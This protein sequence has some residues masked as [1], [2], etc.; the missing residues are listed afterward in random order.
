MAVVEIQLMWLWQIIVDTGHS[1]IQGDESVKACLSFISFLFH[2]GCS[3]ISIMKSTHSCIFCPF[4]ILLPQSLHNRNSELVKVAGSCS[5]SIACFFW[6]CLS[7]KR[8][9]S[10]SPSTWKLIHS[11]S[12]PGV[13]FFFASHFLVSCYAENISEII[14]EEESLHL[15][16]AL[17]ILA[18]SGAKSE[19]FG[20]SLRYFFFLSHLSFPTSSRHWL[21]W[22][23]F[24]SLT[25]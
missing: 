15:E 18:A 3:A 7:L 2:C 10:W 16:S 6:L 12:L 22:Q 4:C 5:R 11:F 24:R 9:S 23:W 25:S 1:M 21:E 8:M 19:L 17:Y 20:I 13:V 14:F